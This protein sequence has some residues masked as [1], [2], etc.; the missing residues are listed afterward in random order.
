MAY[1]TDEQ[2]VEALKAWWD[3]NGTSIIVAV[4]VALAVVGGWRGWQAWQG[5]QAQLASRVYAEL[6]ETVERNDAAAAGHFDTL[7]ADYAG[8]PYATLGAFHEAKRLVEA[9]DLG[10][11]ATALRY[12]VDNADDADLK[13][14]AALRLARVLLEQGDH[15][16]ALDALPAEAPAS[17][18]ALTETVRGDVLLAQNKTAEARAAYE[19]ARESSADV[20]DESLLDMQILDLAGRANP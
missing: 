15:A 9:S 11:A 20:A 17:F 2:Q 14:V 6:I 1:E 5:K 13:A 12:A 3:E 16:A 8:T 7:R 19:R 10:G 4:V 18:E